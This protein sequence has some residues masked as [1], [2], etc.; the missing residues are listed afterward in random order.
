MKLK[1]LRL[2]L[3]TPTSGASVSYWNGLRL[4]V[5]FLPSAL[6]PPPTFQGDCDTG[7]HCKPGLVCGRD[8]CNPSN[9]TV[10][11]ERHLFNSGDDCCEERDFECRG[12]ADCCT[13][14]R[15]CDLGE[16]DC[17]FD[18]HCRG[19]LVCG[20]ANCPLG[21]VRGDPSMCIAFSF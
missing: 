14:E 12:G 18:S 4:A 16:G 8:N 20:S 10:H 7:H 21:E 17:D 13:S 15:P 3:R 1:V 19:A 11:N 2:G 6:T 9:A 5:T